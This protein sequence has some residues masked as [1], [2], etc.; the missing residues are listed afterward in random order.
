MTGFAKWRSLLVFLAFLTAGVLGT[1]KAEARSPVIPG[2]ALV[3][4]AG[5]WGEEP[6]SPAERE[7]LKRRYEEWRTLPPE[8]QQQL[9][10]RLDRLRSLPSRDQELLQERFRQWQK[11]PP[12]ERLRLRRQLEQWES[13]SPQEQDAIRRQFPLP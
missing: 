2:D 4:A 9:R 12:G 3:P 1:G 7:L 6:V 11:I 13:L 5:F 8:R 10:H